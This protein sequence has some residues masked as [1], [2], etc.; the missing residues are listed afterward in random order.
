LIKNGHSS[1][2]S[3]Y[4]KIRK[5]KLTVDVNIWEIIIIIIHKSIFKRRTNKQK[6]DDKNGKKLMKLKWKINVSKNCFMHSAFYVS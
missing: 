1:D 4:F 3:V 2:L 5:M 6:K